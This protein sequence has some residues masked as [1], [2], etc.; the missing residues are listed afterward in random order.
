MPVMPVMPMMSMIPGNTS[1]KCLEDILKLLVLK[2]LSRTTSSLI[3]RPL[4]VLFRAKLVI[5]SAFI[6]VDEG[7][8]RIRY[9]LKYLFGT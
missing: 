6:C 9:F 1:K 7:G 4:P 5:M 3:L 2:V 8:V